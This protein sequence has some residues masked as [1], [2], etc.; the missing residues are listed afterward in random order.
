VVRAGEPGQA[1]AA[2]LADLPA[3]HERDQ[4]QAVEVGEAAGVHHVPVAQHGDRVAD[5]VQLVHAVADVDHG[6]AALAQRADHVE[7]GAHLA[8]FERRGGLVHDRHPCVDGD[9]TREGHHLL[10]PDAE[11][12]QRT[13]HI[14]PDAQAA[15]RLVR[16]PVHAPEVDQA[17]PAAGFAAEEEIAG[18]A[19]Q[20]DEVD[21]LVDGGDARL[22]GLQG[23]GEADR[24]AVV[25][26]LARVR[27]V[28]AGENF[29]QGRL[30]RAVLADE[31][32]DFPGAGCEVHVGQCLHPGEDLAH[33][34]DREHV[35][36][37][38]RGP[39]GRWLWCTRC[40]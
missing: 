20:R 1:L 29:D 21:L 19:H 2:D 30:A 13:A 28:D 26:D 22:L 35:S 7:Q 14:D 34:G 16:L 5:L 38:C 9:R 31:G 23:R 3:Q 12:A 18:H 32:V 40:P 15:Q 39:T 36:T 37:P 17:E 6:D 10:G 8:W 27:L 33:A 4:T 11:F 25:D 24:R